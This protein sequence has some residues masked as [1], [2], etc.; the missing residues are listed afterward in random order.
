LDALM[1]SLNAASSKRISTAPKKA[2]TAPT[3]S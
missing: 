3:P 2:A 1:E